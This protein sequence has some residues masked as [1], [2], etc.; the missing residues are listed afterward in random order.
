MKFAHLLMSFALLTAS[1]DLVLT[2]DIAGTVRF[3]QFMLLGV[4]L[5]AVAHMLET[6][7]I[8]WPRGGY[9]LALW[10]ILQGIFIVESPAPSTSLLLYAVLLFTLLGIAAAL[11]IY[12]RSPHI[13]SLMKVYLYSFVIVSLFGAI[14]FISPALHLGAPLIAQW[15]YPGLIP[16]INGFNYEP[17]YFATYLII[18]WIMVVDLRA[19]HATITQSRRWF[20]FLLLISAILFLSTSKTAWLL[21]MAEVLARF[22]PVVWRH[23]VRQTTRLLRG[24]WIVDLPRGKTIAGVLLVVAFLAASAE[25]ASQFVDLNTFLSGTGINGTAAHSLNDRIGGFAATF[26]VIKLHFWIGRSLGGVPATIA[27]LHGLQLRTISDLRAFWGFPVPLDVFAA[28][29]FWGFIPFLW[30][31]LTITAGERKLIR[32][33]YDDDRAKWLQALIRAL[34]FEWLALC[35]DQNLLRVYLW[36]HVTMIVVVGYNLRYFHQSGK[37]FSSL[38]PQKAGFPQPALQP[39]TSPITRGASTF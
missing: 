10:C 39:A 13:G 8:L 26:E 5:C 32:S 12:G 28:S 16:R 38:A 14:Q 24:S 3:C 22:L 37:D 23:I 25:V 17:S 19:S 15:I 35:A 33:H 9:A 1:C 30:F 11:Q 18:G 21:M 2:V 36:F 4:M 7:T 6:R 27:Q 29:G 20:W 31:F 34:I